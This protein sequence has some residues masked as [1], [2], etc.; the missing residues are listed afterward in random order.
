[1]LGG[2]HPLFFSPVVRTNKTAKSIVYTGDV[3]NPTHPPLAYAAKKKTK[4]VGST[5][6][7]SNAKKKNV[8]R[9]KVE[10]VAKER[11]GGM[12]TQALFTSLGI[13]TQHHKGQT[14]PRQRPHLSGRGGC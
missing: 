1:M 10:A 6:L 11:G 14:R 3:F 13:H 2:A 9:Y 4:P 7:L 12:G 8:P 5:C